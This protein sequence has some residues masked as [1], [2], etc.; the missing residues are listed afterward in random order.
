MIVVPS[1]DDDNAATATAYTVAPDFLTQ[2]N[3]GGD[4]LR[5]PAPERAQE[6]RKSNEQNRKGGT[7]SGEYERSDRKETQRRSFEELRPKKR[8]KKADYGSQHSRLRHLVGLHLRH[9]HPHPVSIPSLLHMQ[10]PSYLPPEMAGRRRIH[11]VRHHSSRGP[12]SDNFH[13]FQAQPSPAHDARDDRGGRDGEYERGRPNSGPDFV[14]TAALAR[15]HFLCFIVSIP[16][17]MDGSVLME[18]ER[19]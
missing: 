13:V 5:V 15:A 17:Y 16:L 1:L 7:G 3:T 9:P 10:G 19:G 2:R 18:N 4:Y 12:D 14:Q 6:R 11:G 8:R